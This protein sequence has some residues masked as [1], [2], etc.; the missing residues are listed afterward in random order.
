MSIWQYCHFAPNPTVYKW[1]TTGGCFIIRIAS[2]SSPPLDIIMKIITYSDLHLEFGTDFQPSPDSDAE[3]MI[4]AGDILTFRD[5]R[6][7][8][9]LLRD[10]KKQVLFVTGNHEYY[11]R[12]PMDKEDARFKSWLANNHPNVTLLQDEAI[13]IEGIHFFGGTMWT[14]FYKEDS[15]AMLTARQQ[16][17]D[18]RHIMTSS[19]D[20]LKPADTIPLHRAFVEKLLAWFEQDLS[21]PHVVISHHAPVVNPQTRYGTSPLMPAFNSLDMPE[22]I[23]KYQPSLWVYGHTHECD[24]QA[25]GKT[26]IISNQLGYPNR[27]GSFECKGFDKAG[28]MVVVS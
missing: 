24:N 8:T 13:S 4:L 28:L 22:I 26:H 20:L 9:Y 7:L 12:Q 10:W 3:L 5:Y 16:M 19:G 25:I 14:D 18:Y 15:L 1:R 27:D 6:P 23:Q 11:T 17:N 2:T 21:G